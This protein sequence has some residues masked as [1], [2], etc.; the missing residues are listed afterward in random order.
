MCICFTVLHSLPKIPANVL[1]TSFGT[2]Q[3]RRSLSNNL[4]L[5]R[6][7]EC[8]QW[9]VETHGTH[10][11]QQQKR[12][13]LVQDSARERLDVAPSGF[14]SHCLA[15]VQLPRRGSLWHVHPPPTSALE[16]RALHC[17]LNSLIR[18]SDGV[19]VHKLAF[20]AKQGF[21]CLEGF[22]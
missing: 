22:L 2:T 20:T 10:A 17:I 8:P 6:V 18:R 7:D 4:Y 15:V 13:G 5:C 14:P 16:P 3:E 9:E 11:R 12:T 1:F 19:P 21:S